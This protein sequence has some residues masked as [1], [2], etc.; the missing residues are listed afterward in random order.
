MR[1]SNFEIFEMACF[2]TSSARAVY[3]FTRKFILT[4]EHLE[5]RVELLVYEHQPIT[6][7]Q[8]AQSFSFF[9]GLFL[10]IVFVKF[11]SS[12]R[13]FRVR[14]KFYLTKVLVYFNPL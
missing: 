10:L 5:A 7:I 8:L 9:L 11:Y 14:Q 12:F 13:I 3:V 2:E 6:G 4:H 1:Y